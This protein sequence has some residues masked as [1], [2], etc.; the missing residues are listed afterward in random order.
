MRSVL[1]D[2]LTDPNSYSSLANGENTIDFCFVFI[3]LHIFRT[4]CDKSV[5][6]ENIFFELNVFL[7]INRFLFLSFHLISWENSL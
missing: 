5:V 4:N 2:A 3:C 6:F 7:I 1:S